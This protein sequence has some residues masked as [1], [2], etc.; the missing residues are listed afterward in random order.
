M[1]YD[2]E[3]DQRDTTVNPTM[4]LEALSESTEGYDRGTKATH[5]R[6]IESLQAYALVSQHEPH[7]ELFE[8]QQD[9][10][11]RLTDATGMDATLPMPAIEIP[12]A[13]LYAGVEFDEP[14]HLKV[15]RER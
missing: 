9:G 7:V 3:D 13:D 10:A 4:L 5:Y 14:P 8:R 2:P 1:E 11:W 15:V 6:R 12:L